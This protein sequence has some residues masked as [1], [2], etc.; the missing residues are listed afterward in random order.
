MKIKIVYCNKILYQKN[1]VS[2]IAPGLYGYFQILKNHAPFISVLGNGIIK[3]Y[4]ENIDQFQEIKI[5]GG[6]LQV[7]KNFILVIL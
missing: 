6:F 2:I 4:I 5:E 3:F 1:I 7:K